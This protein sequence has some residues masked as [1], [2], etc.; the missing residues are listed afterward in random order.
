MLVERELDL[1]GLGARIG[2]GV[3]AKGVWFALFG[4]AAFLLGHVDA[5]EFAGRAGARPSRFGG[6]PRL[7]ALGLEVCVVCAVREC[8]VSAIGNAVECAG[9]AGARPSRFGGAPRLRSL[10]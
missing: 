1:P 2:S 10:G 4:K 6:A 3:W 5:A 8:R 9:R 7:G